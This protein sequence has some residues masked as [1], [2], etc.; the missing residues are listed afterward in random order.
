MIYWALAT[1]AAVVLA[2]SLLKRYTA[3]RLEGIDGLQGI[4]EH[5]P[6][7]GVLVASFGEQPTAAHGAKRP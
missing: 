6:E 3:R 2:G 5:K 1:L 4:T 7:T